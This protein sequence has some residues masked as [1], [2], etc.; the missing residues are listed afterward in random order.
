MCT[1]KAPN[2]AFDFL[3]PIRTDGPTAG[4]SRLSI[5]RFGLGGMSEF[6][7]LTFKT[8]KVPFLVFESLPLSETLSIV[9]SAP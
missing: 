9:L 4:R 5:E 2:F 8:Y 6:M 1:C 3:F 7:G